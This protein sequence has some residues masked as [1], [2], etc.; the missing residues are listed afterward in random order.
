[1]KSLL[2]AAVIASGSVATSWPI[3]LERPTPPQCAPPGAKWEWN[4]YQWVKW[5]GPNVMIGPKLVPGPGAKIQ[6]VSC[7]TPRPGEFISCCYIR[8]GRLD[9][10]WR[11][12]WIGPWPHST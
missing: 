1:M 10:E 7:P 4:G 8:R 6:F 5:S 9:E 2:F 12:E 11:S 3:N